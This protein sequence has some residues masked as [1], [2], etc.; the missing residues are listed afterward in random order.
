LRWFSSYFGVVAI[1]VAFVGFVL[2]ASRAR[3]G[4]GAAATVFLVVVPVTVMYLARPSISPDQPWAMRR[5]LPVV[6]PGLAIAVAVALAT[7]WRAAGS[8][9]RSRTRD[10]AR[11]GMVAVSL[12]VAAP[13]ASAALPLARARAQHGALAAVHH[14]CRAAGDDGAVLVYGYHF[15]DIEL[16]Q[17]IR[18]FCG[19]PV[20]LGTNVDLSLLARQ[21]HD[22]GRRLL[23]ATAVPD[24][25]MQKAPGATIIGHER[26]AGDAEPERVFD[27]APR[28]YKAIPVEI[29]LLQV[30]ANS[31]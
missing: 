2:L 10:A 3:R 12:L 28:R 20:G 14:I 18:G 30:P 11:A 23:V 19:V 8:T 25:V 6:I 24:T 16:P 22:L 1:I 13:T 27:R 26:V 17:P 15:L 29:W 7:G 21:W 4:D 5:Y 9:G 31:P